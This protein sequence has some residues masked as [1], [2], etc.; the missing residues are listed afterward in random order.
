GYEFATLVDAI[1][2]VSTGEPG[3]SGEARDA[4]AELDRDAELMVFT[5]PTCRYCPS[6]VSMANRLALA[7]E[8]VRAVTVASN[9]FPALSRR[10]GVQGVPQTV[11]N[12]E[13]VFVG[14]LPEP[15][16]LQ[17]VLELA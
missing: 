14:A 16:F 11:V 1:E 5:T 9:D 6:A 7:S 8:H 10:F 12:R 15:Q 2:R 17:A 4:I 13:G 3:L